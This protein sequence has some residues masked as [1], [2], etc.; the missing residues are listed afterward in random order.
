MRSTPLHKQFTTLLL[1]LSLSAPLWAG[2][3][4]ADFRADAGLNRVEVKWVVTAES[5]LKGYRV[6]RSLDGV[7]YQKIAFVAAVGVSGREHTYQFVDNSVFKSAGRIFYYKLELINEDGS[8]S[9][10]EKVVSVSPQISSTRHTWGS[11]K[12]MFR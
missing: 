4:I 10:F 12:A 2:A 8:V 9:E 5:G 7:Q 3:V 11:L 6:L 1:V